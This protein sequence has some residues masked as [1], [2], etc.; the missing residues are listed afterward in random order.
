MDLQ[1]NI[2]K[3]LK[4]IEAHSY[5]IWFFSNLVGEEGPRIPGV[6]GPSLFDDTLFL[7]RIDANESGDGPDI[8]PKKKPERNRSIRGCPFF[9][10]KITTCPLSTEAAPSARAGFLTSPS[11]VSFS[12]LPIPIDLDSGVRPC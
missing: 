8:F 2:S 9:I 5:H 4:A 11:T 1:F 10:L 6:K 12:D 3:I 7:K